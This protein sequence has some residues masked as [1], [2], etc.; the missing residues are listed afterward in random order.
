M[1][2]KTFAHLAL[3]SLSLSLCACDK[4][5]KPKPAAPPPAPKQTPQAPVEAEPSPPKEARPKRPLNVLL[6]TVDALRSDMPWTTYDK[7]IAPNLT[8]LAK[9]SVVYENHRSVSSYTAQ[10]VATLMSGRYASTLYRTGVFFTNYFDSNEWITEAMQDKGIRTMAVHAH[11]YFDRAPGLKQGFDIYNMVPGLT[12][13]AQTDES[14]TSH[15][16]IPEIIKLLE[17]PKNTKGQFFLWSHLM[18]PHDQYVKHEESPDFGKDN[19]GRYDSE[20]W[21]TDMW[22]GKL[23]EFGKKQPWWEQTAIIISAD[24]GEAFGEHGMFKHAFEVWDVLTRVPLIVKAPG[25][26]PKVIKEPRTHIDLAPTVMDLM[27]L[28]PLKGFQG[29]TLVPEI[30]GE[31]EPESR[32][33]L[34]LELSEDTNNPSRRAIIEGDYKLIVSESWK[35]QLFNL[36]DDPGEEKDLAEEMPDKVKELEAKLKAEFDALPVIQPFGGNKLKSGKHANGPKGPP[37]EDAKQ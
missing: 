21:Y 14:I 28:E 17:D 16:S 32:E 20:V 19:R 22:L 36:K 1:G 18:D 2:V 13:N 30:Y 6:L 29:E 10:T 33:P 25:A 27:Q 37:K 5:E 4:E 24:H 26:E 23:F 12:W 8:A 7:E 11:L 35:K 34:L 15:K 9:E 31:K 3:F